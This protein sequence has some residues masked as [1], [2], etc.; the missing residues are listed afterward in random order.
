MTWVLDPLPLTA[1]LLSGSSW[2]C[3]IH[4]LNI[5]PSWAPVWLLL[6]VS[7]ARLNIFTHIFGFRNLEAALHE[8]TLEVLFLQSWLL[9]R[10]FEVFETWFGRLQTA[11]LLHW[12]VLHWS[13]GTLMPEM[14]ADL[15][16]NTT[17]MG[18]GNGM[19]SS[20]RY[21]FPSL[22][23]GTRHIPIPSTYVCL[24]SPG[25]QFG[26]NNWTLGHGRPK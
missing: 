24:S 5:S 25:D 23:L 15:D 12:R 20:S 26:L 18:Q 21:R 22:R 6:S 11:I 3:V 10:I 8:K 7:T 2:H 16:R 19:P 1:N 13:V 9:G 14:C 4:W 17:I